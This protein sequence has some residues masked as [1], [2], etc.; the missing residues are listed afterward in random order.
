MHLVRGG[1]CQVINSHSSWPWRCRQGAMTIHSVDFSVRLFSFRLTE[2]PAGSVSPRQSASSRLWAFSRFPGELECLHRT[3]GR[4][5]V[6]GPR[7]LE[8]EQGPSRAQNPKIHI[9]LRVPEVTRQGRGRGEAGARVTALHAALGAAGPFLQCLPLSRPPDE[10]TRLPFP[11]RFG[12]TVCASF[13]VAS[14]MQ[15]KNS[16]IYKDIPCLK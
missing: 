12:A 3:S 7:S 15:F 5:C 1:T 4:S 8:R 10:L 13:M 14:G 9:L 6:P 16:I 11:A 2:R